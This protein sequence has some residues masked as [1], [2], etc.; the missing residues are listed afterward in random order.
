VIQKFGVAHK[1]EADTASSGGEI[2]SSMGGEAAAQDV[3]LSVE[4]R[5]LP[6]QLRHFLI[7]PLSNP[8]RFHKHAVHPRLLYAC[9]DLMQTAIS[10]VQRY[11]E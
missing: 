9:L 1:K 8:Y 6:G 3:E 5:A 7:I 10:K 4:S 2:P 11:F